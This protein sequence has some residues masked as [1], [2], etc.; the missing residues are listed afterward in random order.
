MKATNRNIAK[1]VHNSYHVVTEFNVYRSPAGYFY[2]TGKARINGEERY[3]DIESEY[4]Y[5][6]SQ[7]TFNE[8]VLLWKDNVGRALDRIA[9]PLERLDGCG[10]A[11]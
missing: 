1:A 11:L 8:W 3:L 2:A 10:G 4:T 6:L 9:T 7:R 5:S